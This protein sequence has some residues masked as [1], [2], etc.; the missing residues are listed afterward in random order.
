VHAR[1]SGDLKWKT[2]SCDKLSLKYKLEEAK[3]FLRQYKQRNPE[4]FMKNSMNS[5][6]NANGI[7]CKKNSADGITTCKIHSK[8]ENK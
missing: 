7:Q 8:K 2:T 4:E 6:L 1:W 5:D 3:K